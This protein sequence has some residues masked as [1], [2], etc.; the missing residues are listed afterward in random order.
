MAAPP[1]GSQL[2][3][4]GKKYNTDTDADLILD[5]VA[6]AGYEAV[7]SGPK[8][9]NAFRRKL[10]QRNLRFG[11]MHVGLKQL[12]DVKPVIRYLDALNGRDVCNSG[13]MT[14]E[15]RSMR[16]YKEG[17]AI[18][19]KAGREL[20]KH[21]IHLHYHNHDFEFQRVAENKTGMDILIQELD[22]EAADL[23]VDVAWV[24]R[25]GSDPAE[26][27]SRHADAV[28]Y[29]HFKDWNGSQWV[30]LGRGKVDFA[31]IMQVIPNLR[32]ARWIMIEQDDTSIEPIESAT[33][34][35]R[36]LKEKFGY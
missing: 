3:V 23:C 18:L 31:R 29:L 10:E 16:D 12:L 6:A 34:S 17:I 9:P 22:P 1:V 13:F 36:F 30:E 2:L 28:G 32:K 26:F 21:G 15:S 7:E 11:G 4:F 25:G 33:I 14:W 19:N 27:L 35:R 24:L 5:A 20:R 8:D